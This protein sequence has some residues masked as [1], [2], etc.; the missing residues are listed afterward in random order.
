[1][2]KLKAFGLHIGISTTLFLLL[3]FLLFFTGTPYP[4]FQRMV[5][6]REFA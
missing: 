3:L 1:M 4:I 5:V 6:G 2:G